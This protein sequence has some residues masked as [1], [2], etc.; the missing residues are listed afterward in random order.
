M[1]IRTVT[2]DFIK[3]LLMK[4]TREDGRGMGA[5][6]PINIA[7][8]TIP[9]AEG[10]ATVD[11]GHTKVLCG[12]KIG[13]GEPMPDKPKDGNIIT[14]AE[15][16]PLA[17]P[18][19][20]IGP[21]TPEAIEFARVVDR[22]IR[23]AKVIPTEKMFIEEEK[24]WEV[25]IDLYVL[26]YDGNLFDA[27]TM[28]AVAAIMSARMP[29][30]EGE[31]VIREG[32]L[33]KFETGNVIS[34]CTYAKIGNSIVLDPDGNEEASMDA[35]ITIANDENYVRAMQKGAGG[36]FTFKE[37]EELIEKTFEKSKELRGILKKAVGE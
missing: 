32:S 7:T 20:D 3:D 29:K 33:G 6:R 15:L 11:M 16:L 34:S 26:N 36:S 27:G 25:Y 19:Y 17:S 21:P 12:V 5:Y 30:Y 28:S 4:G 14:S 35:R 2:D 1:Q 22:G 18:H 9:N 31:K 24:V 23:A 37:T 8:G 13:V 10:S